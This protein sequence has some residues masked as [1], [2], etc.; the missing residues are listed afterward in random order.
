MVKLL[1]ENGAHVHGYGD[2]DGKTPLVRASMRGDLDMVKLLIEKG[3]NIDDISYFTHED[4]ATALIFA[5][6]H[7][8]VEI[9][10]LLIEE[11]AD[12][13]FAQHDLCVVLVLCLCQNSSVFLCLSY[14]L[15]SN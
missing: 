14:M 11:G 2:A 12:V 10:K 3:A 6:T 1:T 9:V 5:S 8:H 15:F 13:N 7:G 4:G